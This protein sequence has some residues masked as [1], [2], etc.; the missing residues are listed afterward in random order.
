MKNLL[1][2]FFCSS[3]VLGYLTTYGQTIANDVTIG[4]KDLRANKDTISF[5]LSLTNVSDQSVVLFKPNL[6]YVN[7]G[8][9]GIF[10]KN[11]STHKKFRFDNGERGDLDN[12]FLKQETYIVLNKD[13]T[14]ITVFKL[15]INKFSPRILN[16]DYQVEFMLD[17]S[18]TNFTFPCE[19]NA[20][21]FKSKSSILSAYRIKL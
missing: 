19:I 11:F 13:E 9:I 18:I 21:V 10:L 7:Y 15:A 17:Y 3:L 12:I 20:V 16:G 14:F 6:D 2:G 4:I 5:K 8:L 1:I